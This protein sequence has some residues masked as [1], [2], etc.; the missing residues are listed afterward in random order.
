MLGKLLISAFMLAKVSKK[1][2]RYHLEKNVIDQASSFLPMQCDKEPSQFFLWAKP[3]RPSVVKEYHKNLNFLV[4][5]KTNNL[6]RTSVLL[7]N[8]LSKTGKLLR[9]FYC[10]DFVLLLFYFLS[11]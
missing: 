8:V 5:K 7:L 3:L 9:A 1:N 10:L 4:S 11:G 2:C 6:S